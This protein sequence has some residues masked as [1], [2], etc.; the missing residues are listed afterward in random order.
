MKIRLPVLKRGPSLSDVQAM[1]ERIPPKD[2]HQRLTVACAIKNR[3]GSNGW[4]MFDEWY[5]SGAGARYSESESRSMWKSI[6]PNGGI[7]FGSLIHLA[8]LYGWERR[9]NRRIRRAEV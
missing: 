1:L 3:L 5:R 7:T 9:S 2:H 4:E 6:D 8:K